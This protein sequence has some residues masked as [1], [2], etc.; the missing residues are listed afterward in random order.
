MWIVDTREKILTPAAAL[1]IARATRAN[2]TP[3]T[4]V[5]GYFDPL[6]A[7]HARRLGEIAG[8][9]GFLIAVVTEPERPIL[10]ARARAELVAALAVVDYV[11]SAED[12][13][14]LLAQLP[15]DRV[16]REEAADLRRTE[17]LVARVHQKGA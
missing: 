1:E 15:A 4:V 3:V 7:G 11:V 17:E 2:G 6:L 14:E 8:A 9:G 10:P 13:A 16:F 12:G 5:T